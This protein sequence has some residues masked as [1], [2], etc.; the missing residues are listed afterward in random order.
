MDIDK[1]YNGMIEIVKEHGSDK[2]MA[3]AIKAS[4]D[5]SYSLTHGPGWYRTEL[6]CQAIS[7]LTLK[8]KL[9]HIE[10][11]SLMMIYLKI[12]PDGEKRL[13]EILKLQKNYKFNICK[14]QIENYKKKGLMKG[15][16]C[17]KLVEWRICGERFSTCDKY[18]GAVG[19]ES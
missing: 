3:I 10:R 12:G 5:G 19:D 9:S 17:K 7:A 13:W 16:T 8:K 18:K 15:L 2:L 11:T 4:Q 14:S 6:T 1:L